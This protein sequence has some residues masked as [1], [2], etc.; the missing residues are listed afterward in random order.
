MSAPAVCE[1]CHA[2][3]D[4]KDL[5]DGACSPGCRKGLA[6]PPPEPVHMLPYAAA[7][8]LT[9]VILGAG[10]VLLALLGMAEKVVIK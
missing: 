8:T 2:L 10:G 5:H 1:W 3:A 9:G 6:L 4:A 7:F